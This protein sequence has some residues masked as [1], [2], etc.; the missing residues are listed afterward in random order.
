MENESAASA[1]RLGKQFKVPVAPYSR[2]LI[3]MIRMMLVV[4]SSRRQTAQQLLH[5]FSSIFSAVGTVGLSNFVLPF[6]IPCRNLNQYS[7]LKVI[8][9]DKD[10][11]CSLLKVRRTAQSATPTALTLT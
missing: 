1:L 2:E 4:D 6:P 8:S 3:E 9:E 11:G 10:N 7:T 5:R